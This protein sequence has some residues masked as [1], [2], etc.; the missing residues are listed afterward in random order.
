MLGAVN[1][2]A[3]GRKRPIWCLIWL[4][5]ALI[6]MATVDRIPDP[7]AAN[8]DNPQFGIS[9]VHE[10]GMAAVVPGRIQLTVIHQPLGYADLDTN[11][12]FPGDRSPVCL[13]RAT[14]PSPP[15]SQSLLRI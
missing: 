2:A 10:A 5:A 7:P 1:R 14:D 4:L 12:P 8:R 9:C 11:E 6:V 13:E 3:E 15:L